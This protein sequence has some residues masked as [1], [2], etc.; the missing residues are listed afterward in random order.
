[1]KWRL[2]ALLGPFLGMCLIWACVYAFQ[3]P[4][5]MVAFNFLNFPKTLTLAAGPYVF[6]CIPLPVVS[7]LRCLWVCILTVALTVASCFLCPYL[8]W[9]PSC[10]GF[11]LLSSEL[12]NAETTPQA[13]LR[14]VK[15][16][17][18]RSALLLSEGGNWKLWPLL[19]PAQ[20]YTRLGSRGKKSE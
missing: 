2:K 18:I 1:M 10:G 14:Q 4:V 8:A 5:Q 3:F 12:G 16:L 6:C 7:C 17:Q 13:V 11:C 20:G 15:M 9:E 19:P